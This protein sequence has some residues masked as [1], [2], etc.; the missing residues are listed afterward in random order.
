MKSLTISTQGPKQPAGRPGIDSGKSWSRDVASERPRR[1]LTRDISQIRGSFTCGMRSL[2]PNARSE[3]FLASFSITWN[4]GHVAV[5]PAPAPIVARIQLAS[6]KLVGLHDLGDWN[7][8]LS[9]L[10]RR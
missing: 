1:K 9:P 4:C 2:R 10:P 7:P 3:T 5:I 6:R 8:M